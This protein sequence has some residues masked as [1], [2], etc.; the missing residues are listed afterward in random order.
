MVQK[1]LDKISVSTQAKVEK[2]GDDLLDI[3]KTN[4]LKSM[5]KNIDMDTLSP[6]QA[7]AR[8]QELVELAKRD[9]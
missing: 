3:A 7:F 8:L 4:E 5:L 2:E 9:N 1:L 6:I